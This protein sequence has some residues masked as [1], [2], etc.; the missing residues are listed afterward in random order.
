MSEKEKKELSD[1][2]KEYKT[3]FSGNRK[4]AR[5][6]LEDA[7]IITPKGNLKARYKNLPLC[8]PQEPA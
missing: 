8:I 6:F 2:L 5:K 4:A 1:A 7:G 3:K